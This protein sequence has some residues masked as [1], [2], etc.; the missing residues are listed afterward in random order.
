MP[1]YSSWKV[2][3]LKAELKRRGIPQTGLRLKQQ[4]IDRLIQ[5]DA[6]EKSA[7]PSENVASESNVG[8]QTEATEVPPSSN[9]PEVPKSD[10]APMETSETAPGSADSS[11]IAP[12]SVKEPDESSEPPQDVTM[13]DAS[14]TAAQEVT[15]EPSRREPTPQAPAIQE[16]AEEKE[17]EKPESR[18]QQEK[19]AFPEEVEPS[20][21][22]QPTPP[23]TLPESSAS[24]DEADDSKK[25]KRRSQSPPPSPRSLALKR[26]KAD[27]GHPRVILQEDIVAADTEKIISSAEPASVPQAMEID[28]QQKVR[29]SSREEQAAQPD[30]RDQNEEAITQ[31][32]EDVTEPEVPMT[33]DRAAPEEVVDQEK[34]EEHDRREEPEEKPAPHEHES[35]Q[36]HGEERSEDAHSAKRPAGD[37]RFKGLFSANGAP[38]RLESPPPVEDDER[39]VAPAL[40]P[41]TTSLYIR[42]FMRPLQPATLKKHLASLATPPGATPD[43]DIIL[44]F[45]L[46][47][48]KTHCFVTFTSVSAASRVRATLHDTV[49]PE[50]RSRKP[51]WAD[52]IP[53][54]KVKEWI[55]IETAPGN[56]GRDA[57]RWEVIYED[58]EDGMTA[59]LQ[60][61]PSISS[62][63]Q[64]NSFS[65]G[66]E[67]PTGPRADRGI[68]RG[69]PQ[70]A[71]QI[72]IPESGFKALDDR[73][74]STTAKPKLYFLPVSKEVSDKRLDRFDDLARAGPVRKPGGDEMRR[75]T[76][77]DTDYFVDQGPEYGARRGGRG[78]RGRGGSGFAE[79]GGSWRGRR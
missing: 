19:A 9:A 24:I 7:A 57:P 71:P 13:Q 60:E 28:S 29:E 77:E 43:P 1:D 49:W 70:A 4:I 64:G 68:G 26:A 35:P 63:S 32:P 59:V 5:S 17:Q 52:F 79:W 20:Q 65:L 30:D 27:D 40:H 18:T 8:H 58:R 37:A 16:A 3:D 48:I 34:H 75:Y 73:F 66:R 39:A 53:E 69:A 54:E 76:F 36:R 56:T 2:P 31:K 21:P 42:D 45:F 61:A 41:A 74:K 12:A 23:A 62:R 78:P 55:G 11:T 51:L 6:A 46:D 50:E 25:R 38:S 72:K 14:P 10:K 47:S 33:Q 67:P 44:D 22:I 15:V